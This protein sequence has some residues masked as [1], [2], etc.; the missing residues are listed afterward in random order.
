MVKELGELKA[1]LR[2]AAISETSLKDTISTLTK[3]KSEAEETIIKERSQA[4][5]KINKLEY[6]VAKLKEELSKKA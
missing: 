5:E 6:E 1:G 3:Q 2:A 4:E